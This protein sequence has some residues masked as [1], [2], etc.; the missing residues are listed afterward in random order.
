[1]GSVITGIT[2]ITIFVLKFSSICK[3]F[4]W[5]LE[6][7]FKI[8]WK[9]IG[10]EKRLKEE[11]AKWKTELEQKL[12]EKIEKTLEKEQKENEKKFN[13]AYKKIAEIYYIL[14]RDELSAINES[15][16]EHWFGHFMCLASFYY[17]LTKMSKLDKNELIFVRL[18]KKF[19]NEYNENIPM[20]DVKFFYHLLTFIEHSEKI[21]TT[22]FEETKTIYNKLLKIFDYDKIVEYIK[23]S[24]FDEEKVPNF[25][26]LAKSYKEKEYLKVFHFDSDK[27]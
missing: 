8:I 22:I 19:A 11:N 12:K 3:F 27:R 2:V 13:N 9:I 14:A 7:Y 15:K 26:K 17:A 21:D 23:N 16:N 5:L 10:M 6:K 4:K 24:E 1:V 18:V 20:P 25:L